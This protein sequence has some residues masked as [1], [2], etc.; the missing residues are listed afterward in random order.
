MNYSQKVLEHFVNPR[1]SGEM[2]NPDAV[3]VS[4]SEKC[5]DITRIYLNIENNIISEAKF[6]T[7]GCCAAIATSSVTTELLQGKTIE[8]AMQLTESDIVQALDGLPPD[9]MHCP[10]IAEQAVKSALSD[11]QAKHAKKGKLL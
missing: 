10:A 7:F 5:G 4:G 9:K 1:N 11:Y 6:Q 3:G 8:Q 2:E